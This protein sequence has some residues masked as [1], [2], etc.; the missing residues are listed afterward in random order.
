MIWALLGAGAFFVACLWLGTGLYFAEQRCEILAEQLRREADA[1]V[2]AESRLRVMR[3]AIGG[4][5]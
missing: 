1:R 2:R 4:P 5:R 3:A